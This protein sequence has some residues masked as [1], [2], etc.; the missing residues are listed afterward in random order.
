ME[1]GDVALLI[2]AQEV[3]EYNPRLAELGRRK[4]VLVVFF[5]SLLL[6]WIH[7]GTLREENLSSESMKEIGR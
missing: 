7:A 2:G 5:L 4:G 1:R 3:G 6:A